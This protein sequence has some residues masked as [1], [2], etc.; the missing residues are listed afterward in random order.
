MT[1]L[2]P[3]VD[4]DA[5]DPVT[6]SRMDRL[7]AEQ[8]KVVGRLGAHP[9][10]A[11]G[12]AA[13]V[14]APRHRVR[15]V[16]ERRR[17]RRR[18]AGRRGGVP[19]VPVPGALRVPARR[20]CS[21]SAPA[22]ATRIPARSPGSP[23][24]AGSRRRR[25]PG[26]ATCRRASGS[27]RSWWRGSRSCWPRGRCSRCLRIVHALIWHTRAGKVPSMARA[28]GVL[29]LIVTFA[30]AVSALDR[31]AARRVV[32]CSGWW[33]RILWILLPVG[34]VAVRVVAHAP[35]ARR[36]VD[37]VHPRCGRLRRRARGVAPRD[38]LL[39]RA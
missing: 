39:D 16:R 34:R 11:R 10:A 35:R 23:G 19:G 32:R 12:V 2:P 27:S 33:R 14:E 15:R 17:R 24:S 13:E 31:Q 18:G 29:V 37:G 22:P 9:P 25:S 8:A 36:A 6:G 30:L 1:P 5:D 4:P 28:A 3:P 20:R 26:S 7:R 21:A 38:R